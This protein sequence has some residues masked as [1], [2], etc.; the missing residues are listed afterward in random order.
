M[1]LIGKVVDNVDKFKAYRLRISINGYNSEI[2]TDKLPW[3]EQSSS[4]LVNT[5]LVPEIG[6]YVEVTVDSG[7]YTWKYCDIKDKEL[8]KLLGDDYLKSIVLC[9]RNLKRQGHNGEIG[10]LWTAT[11]G[12][13]MKLNDSQFQIRDNGDLVASND[14]KMIHINGDNISFGSENKSA[15]PGVLGDKNFDSLNSLNDYILSV[16]TTVHTHAT[17][18][19]SASK[20]SPFTVHLA[21]LFDALV[22][23]LSAKQLGVN[24][25]KTKAKFPLTKSKIITLD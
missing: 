4:T 21:P 3:I 25:V 7:K 14:K 10:L 11:D 5:G 1:K 2:D 13:Q 23:E 24:Y 12:F 18:L 22:A 20:L 9:Y 8:I 16:A 17:L 19:G 6:E 15:E